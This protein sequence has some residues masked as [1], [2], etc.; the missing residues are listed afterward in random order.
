MSYIK[1]DLTKYRRVAVGDIIQ[2]DD[3]YQNWL[4]PNSLCKM[5]THA[6]QYVGEVIKPSFC[7]IYRLNLT[8]KGNKYVS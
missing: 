5:R 1:I 7:P 3:V 6:P 2:P 8:T 4:Q